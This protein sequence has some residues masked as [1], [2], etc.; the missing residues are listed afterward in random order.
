MSQYIKYLKPKLLDEV[1]KQKY[2]EQQK[3]YRNKRLQ[4]DNE[5]KEKVMVR[6]KQRNKTRYQDDEAYR[7][8][9]REQVLERYYEKKAIQFYI[10]LF[11]I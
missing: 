2:Q 11:D 7:V 10:N 8:K 5:F 4:E 6:T 3:T 1:Y 9:K